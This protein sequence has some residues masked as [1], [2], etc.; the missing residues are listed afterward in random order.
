MPMYL[1]K[2][3]TCGTE[4]EME[5]K[6]TDKPILLNPKGACKCPENTSEVFRQISKNIAFVF[7]GSGFYL[8]DYVHKNE[9]AA[10]NGSANNG[11]DKTGLKKNGTV[12]NYGSTK[13]GSNTKSAEPAAKVSSDK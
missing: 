2:C 9:S 8:T 4:F 12:K 1:Y 10:K 5:Q 7:N 13:K 11:S 3:R 6:I